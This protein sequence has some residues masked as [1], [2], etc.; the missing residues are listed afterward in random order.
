MA[1]RITPLDGQ[2][3]RNVLP[4]RRRSEEL[5]ALPGTAA[6]GPAAIS[7]DGELLARN[8][9]FLGAAVVLGALVCGVSRK[10]WMQ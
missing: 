8:V 1:E 10:V 5:A 6:G 4:P 9:L 7:F 3:T 2:F